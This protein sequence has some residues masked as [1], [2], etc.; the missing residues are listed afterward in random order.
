MLCNCLASLVWFY[1]IVM[2]HFTAI[3]GAVCGNCWVLGL[4]YLQPTIHSQMG[5]PNVL[6]RQWNRLSTVLYG[7]AWVSLRID[8]ANSLAQSNW[9]SIQ[10][11]RILQVFHPV[12]WFLARSCIYPSMLWWVQLEMCQLHR[13]LLSNSVSWLILLVHLCRG[14]RNIRRYLLIIVDMRRSLLWVIGFCWMLLTLVS[15]GPAYYIGS[16]LWVY[17]F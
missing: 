10:L 17:S 11:F 13:I 2:L 15:L 3:F 6:I 9:L 5:R 7:L 16:T 14:R 8:G 1:M 4:H 12:N